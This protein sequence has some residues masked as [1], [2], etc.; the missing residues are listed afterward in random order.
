MSGP[1]VT[2]LVIGFVLANAVMLGT[3]WLMW[4]E[5]KFAGQ[6]QNR[7]GPTEVGST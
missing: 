1:W 7:P 6:M 4:F 5:R 3:A 2:P